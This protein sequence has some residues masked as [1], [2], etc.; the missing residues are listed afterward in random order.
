MDSSEKQFVRYSVLGAAANAW[1][2]FHHLWTQRVG[3]PGYVKAD[4]LKLE[5]ELFPKG[6]EIAP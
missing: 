3:S 2:I 4:W 1:H 6:K 5:A